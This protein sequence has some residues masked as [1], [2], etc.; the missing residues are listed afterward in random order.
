MRRQPSLLDYVFG[1]CQVR[2]LTGIDFSAAS[3]GTVDQPSIHQ[4]TGPS[5]PSPCEAMVT[6][7][8]SILEVSLADYVS[9]G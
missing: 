6:A 1:G 7:L 2:W 8:G 4:A 5:S 9:P 3:R